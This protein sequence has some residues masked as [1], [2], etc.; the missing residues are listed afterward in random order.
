[1][2]KKFMASAIAACVLISTG[3]S[4]ASAVGQCVFPKTVV[5]K[6]GHLEYKRP[7]QLFSSPSAEAQNPKALTAFSSFT[8]KAE[9]GKFIQ[10]A[11]VA[12]PDDPESEKN[13]GK[14][15]GWVKVSDFDFVPLRNCNF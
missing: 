2:M 9:L 11:A 12:N 15:V 3:A 14:P 1:M 8:V 5:K 7:I 6:D 13:A 10:L 4:A